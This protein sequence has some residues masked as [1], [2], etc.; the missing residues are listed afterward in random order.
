MAAKDC[1]MNLVKGELIILPIGFKM[2]HL[3]DCISTPVCFVLQESER[4]QQLQAVLQKGV[5][6]ILYCAI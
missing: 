1:R 2:T 5:A 4:L 3:C 6:W